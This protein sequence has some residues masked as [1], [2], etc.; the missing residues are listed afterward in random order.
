M[1]WS[2]PSF[3]WKLIS[4]AAVLCQEA[5][6]HRLP[7][8]STCDKVRQQ[9]LVFW[10]VWGFDVMFSFNLGRSPTLPDH[11]ITTA[12]P[13]CPGDVDAPWGYG[14]LSWLDSIDLQHEI[15][16]QLYSGRAQAQ[17]PEVKAQHAQ[18]LAEKLIAIR[19]AFVA[20]RLF[21]L[22]A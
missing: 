5:G 14:F 20:V 1:E 10:Y 7:D 21:H 2:N 19:Q 16:Q 15:Y 8:M 17:P 13:R 11:D 6:Y 18:V 4:H 12:R 3:D 22:N 9:R